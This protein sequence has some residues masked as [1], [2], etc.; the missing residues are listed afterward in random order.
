[1]SV[2]DLSKKFGG[3]DNSVVTYLN[4]TEKGKASIDG[5]S[6]SIDNSATSMVSATVKAKLLSVALNALTGLAISLVIKGITW[7]VDEL[8]VTLDEQKEKLDDAVNAYEES[9]TE[10][11]KINEELKTT[12][13]RIDE[14]N[15]K[16]NLTFTEQDELSRLI[17]TNDELER[18]INLLEQANKK[19]EKEVADEAQNTYN[20]YTNG[21]ILNSVEQIDFYTNSSLLEGVTWEHFKDDLPWL[22]AQYKRQQEGLANEQANG[23]VYLEEQSSKNLELLEGYISDVSLDY[24]DL[25]DKISGLSDFAMTDELE[26]AKQDLD[27]ILDI[28][29]NIL[30]YGGQRSETNFDDIWNSDDFA[31]YKKEL[32]S[33]AREGKL[34]ASALESNEQYRVLLENTG[35]T[36]EETAQHI[37]ALVDEMEQSGETSYNIT[38]IT[39][40]TAL[41]T[42]TDS[43]DKFQSS[44]KSAA[45]A[46]TTLLTGNY[47]SSEL[48]DSIQ[49]INKAASDMGES[50]DW[51]SIV[52]SDNPLQA[53]QDEIESVSNTYAESVLS[54]SGIDTDS[55][56]GQMLANIVQAAYKSETALSSLNTQIDSLQS[57]YDDLADIVNTY[58]ETG[59]ITFDQLQTLL[60]MEP[61]YLSCLI[62]DNGQLQLNQEA[63]LAL[64]NQRLND[65]EA[66]A[67]QQAITE[68]GQLTLQDEKTAVE[69]NAQA[70]SNAV[71]DLAVYNEELANT[72]GEASVASSAICD[73]NAAISGAES[74]GAT[75]AQI[76][77][78]LNNLNTKL[79]LIKNTRTGLNKNIGNIMGGSGS[80]SSSAKS[81]F[82]ETIDFFKERVQ[83]LDDALSHLDTTMDNVSGSFGKNNLVDAQLGINE[84]KFNNYT[85]ALAMYTQKANE[86]FAKIPADIASRV[87]DG[88]V[89][90][91]DFV[92]DGNKDVVEAIK[93]YQSWADEI[94][95]CKEELA[96]LEK[97]IRQLELEKFNNIMDDFKSQ[98]DLRGDSKDLISKQIDL[99]KEAGEL[100]GE[101]FYT[102]QI[103]Q[104]R[105]QLELLENEKAQLVNQMSS[106]VNSGRV[107]K[108][109]DEWLE[110]VNALSDVDGSILDCKKSIEGFDNSLL[111]LHTEIF[112]RI[113]EQFSN[114]DS[115]ISNLIDLFDEFEISDEKGIWSKEGLTQLGL[116]TQ[117]YELAQYQI[118]QYNK[119]IDE[120][121]RQYL[122]GRYSATEYAD[123]LADLSSAQWD[124]VKATESAKDA[125][126][127]LNETRIEN[128][129]KGIEKEINAYK[130]LTDAQIEALK[131][132]KDLHDYEK[133]IAEKTKSIT[134]LERQIAA[135]QNDTS[136]ATIAKR[137][138]LE[139]QL[140]DARADIE[141]TQYQH[142]IEVQEEALNR[143]YED[144]EKTRNEEIDALRESLNDKEALLAQSFETV[145]ANA[146]SVGQEITWIAAQ[147]GVSVS[148]S[149]ISSWQSGERAIASYGEVLSQGTSA[150]I[151]NIMGVENEVWN[152]Q[153]QANTTADSLAWMFSTK[154]DALVNELASS[155]YCEENLR[156]MTLALQDSLINT[157]ERGYDVSSIVNSINSISE[158]AKRAKKSID[159]LLGSLPTETTSNS[160]IGGGGGGGN[161]AFTVA[162]VTDLHA[163]AG[164][165][166]STKGN[167]F[168]KD[169]NGY[170]LLNKLS[171]GRY[172]VANEGSQVFTKEQTDHLYEQSKL[173]PA[174]WPRFNTAE[175]LW[176]NAGIMKPMVNRTVNNSTPVQIGNLVNVEGNVGSSDIRQME[177]IADKAVN[178][179]VNRLHDGITYGR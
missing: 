2:D 107:R 163:Y 159:E 115:E 39:I 147:H 144:Y 60:A 78:V 50:I 179:L 23:W 53:I 15:G 33:L 61:Q 140:A 142:S 156:T 69:E 28:V 44:V 35:A 118:Q 40:S 155:Y 161:R 31:Q 157:L 177:V 21:R 128:Q 167:L 38:P 83:I 101:S 64:A 133:S 46:Y 11:E 135:M 55:K 94:S 12:A 45:D 54:G 3:L 169:E 100:I 29:A 17:K 48:L 154:A 130:E 59:Y 63:M 102:A 114:L 80:G 120:L 89:A 32:E 141:E 113:Q 104:S 42:S 93:D 164:G 56:F 119:E 25:Y 134:D 97:E 106:A 88:A 103:D 126:M 30:G 36:A 62:D 123:R 49:A 52:S 24:Q 112:N 19:A 5:L 172:A 77:T 151:G 143:Q 13:S 95:A 110:M 175:N 26:L 122:S 127:D 149:L 8:T 139:Q 178:K 71:N 16:D 138:Q 90:L 176:K 129:I 84:E 82:S 124:A 152:L 171:S 111:E 131:A 137:K 92:G 98:F 73:L 41:T 14:L 86:A 37:R 150:F 79:Q 76:D 174:L 74:Q 160:K 43:L 20:K 10:L 158:S 136:A 99:L 75:D 146:S 170:E 121:N 70:F 65:A 66:Q 47:S 18:K 57:A 27:D 166:R 22:I 9:R 162:T 4:S 108:E 34:N 117:Q 173:D 148:N 6:N 72:I 168:I 68:L 116:L 1:M 87:K 132:S 67:V 96:K 109:T 7:A 81:D 91:T 58:N 105:K 153:A 85:D 125:I 51:E 145:K 165:T